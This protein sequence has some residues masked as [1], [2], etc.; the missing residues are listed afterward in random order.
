MGSGAMLFGG[1]MAGQALPLMGAIFSIVSLIVLTLAKVHRFVIDD[2]T[3][4]ARITNKTNCWWSSEISNDHGRGLIIGKKTRFIAFS[5][6]S[7]RFD[8]TILRMYTTRRIHDSLEK[9]E[10]VAKKDDT[11]ISMWNRSGSCWDLEYTSTEVP[12]SDAP[13]KK[14]SLVIDQIVAR[15]EARNHSV[16]FIYGEKGVGKS[17]IGI[18]LAQKLKCSLCDS[19]EMSFPGDSFS[20][21]VK[22]IEPTKEKPLILVIDEADTNIFA[23][24]HGMNSIHKEHP[25]EICSKSTWNK[26]FD[27]IDRG[28]FPW[29]IVV[30]TSNTTIGAINELDPS[31]LRPGR[32]DDIFHFDASYRY[33]TDASEAV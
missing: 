23:I 10:L 31:Y 24:D 22:Q 2:S 26:L 6:S 32:V 33:I 21:M 15:F 30:M 11:M 18:F 4:V 8:R 13:S 7:S 19:Y 20:N 14:Q 27:H 12:I 28:L 3:T 29:V 9:I 17:T 25:V 5:T 1:M 16:S